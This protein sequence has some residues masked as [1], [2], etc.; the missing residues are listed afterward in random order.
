MTCWRIVVM[1]ALTL[2][3]IGCSKSPQEQARDKLVAQM[4]VP[5]APGEFLEAAQNGK[6]NV[7]AL[8]LEAGM[9][10]ET[11]DAQGRTALI[12]AAQQG[13]ADTVKIL[14]EKGADPNNADK[15][16]KTPLI[17][18]CGEDQ[19]AVAL[20]LLGKGTNVNA[21]AID[22]TTALSAANKR[23]DS[24]LVKLLIANGAT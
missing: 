8:F 9:D 6:N 1:A 21:K 24:E 15:E 17:W 12:L 19:V 11:A 20:A 7:V 10:S 3:A 16:G 13:H 18:A 14:L 5:W 23:G 2:A 22:G 4:G